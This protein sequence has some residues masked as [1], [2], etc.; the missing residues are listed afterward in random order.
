MGQI[1]R[2]TQGRR[3]GQ[4]KGQG[5]TQDQG[6]GQGQGQT[7]GKGQ[8]QKLILIKEQD[9]ID[10]SLYRTVMR[11]HCAMEDGTAFTSQFQW[12]LTISDADYNSTNILFPVK[13]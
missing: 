11:A 10:I 7:K 9:P 4:T 8:N 12:D 5:Q 2:K 6:Q 3:Q 13:Y 1:K